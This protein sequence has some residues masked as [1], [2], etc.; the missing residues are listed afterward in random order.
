MHTTS[1][2][3]STGRPRLLAQANTLSNICPPSPIDAQIELDTHADTCVLG[4]NFIILHY[5]GRVCDVSPYSS[6]YESVK[7]VPIV[8][9]ATAWTDRQTGETYILIVHEALWMADRLSH[10]LINPNQLRAFGTLVQDNPF[11]PPLELV[12]P[13]ERIRIPMRLDGTNVVFT[14]R[15]PSQDELETCTHIHLTSQREWDPMNFTTPSFE[16]SQ[17]VSSIASARIAEGEGIF[18]SDNFSLKLLSKFSGS[19]IEAE[20]T[21][22]R[23]T[24]EVLTELRGP[25]TFVTEDRRA[26]VSPQSLADRWLI[27][28]EQAKLTL[29]STTQ[30][31]LRSAHLPLARRYKA[32]RMFFRPQLKG[33]WY[34]DTVFVPSKSKDGNICG[35]IYANGNYFVAFYPMDSK[36]KAGDSLRAFCREFG[37]PEKLRHDGAPEMVGRKTEFQRTIRKYGIQTHV[38]EAGLHNQSPAEGVVREVRRKWFR[39]VFKKRVPVKFWDYG[40]RWVCETMSRTH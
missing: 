25:P 7:N 39:V 35:Q 26:D 13:D 1:H 8:S 33:E 27:G 20:C 18:Y 31:F 36:S 30:T 14:T 2:R 29:K 4:T 10:S 21:N 11:V 38:S 3:H 12:D 5:T 32:D 6:E 15:T 37:I 23:V 24:S 22:H 9:G 19:T 17:V 40:M 34:T 28:L 16:L